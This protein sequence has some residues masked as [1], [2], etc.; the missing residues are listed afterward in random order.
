MSDTVSVTFSHPH[1]GRNVGDTADLERLE[2]KRL[3]RA[4]V[5]TYT[6]AP[7]A[8]AAEGEQGKARTKRAVSS[9]G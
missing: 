5:A 8:V 2:A 6:T 1:D 9:G 7:D 4:G 3:V